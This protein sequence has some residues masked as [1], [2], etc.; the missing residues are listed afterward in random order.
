MEDNQAENGCGITFMGEFWYFGDNEKVSCISIL[1]LDL[2]QFQ[3]SK[4]IGCQL[5]RQ[6]DMD[7]KFNHGSCNTFIQPSPKILLCFDE[8]NER[9]CHT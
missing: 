2:R 1:D 7:F 5:V 4:V 6:M 8:N 9:E 3:V